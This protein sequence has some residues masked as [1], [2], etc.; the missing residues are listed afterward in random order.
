[1]RAVVWLRRPSLDRSIACGAS[2]SPLLRLRAAQLVSPAIRTATADLIEFALAEATARA[3]LS[4]DGTLR[5]VSIALAHAE[6]VWLAAALRTA[7]DPSAQAVAMALE[8][9]RDDA[10]PLH[11]PL[12]A[13]ALRTSAKQITAALLP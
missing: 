3:R 13:T 9:V 2:D 1:M 10:S 4:D 11:R 5:R 12:T 6:L 7:P 8:L